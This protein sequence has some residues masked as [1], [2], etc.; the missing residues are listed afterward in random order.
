MI[1]IDERDLPITVAQKLITAT[2][3]IEAPLTK[4]I[5]Q[6]LGGDGTMDA[7]S[8]DEL[9]EIAEYLLIHCQHQ[10]KQQGGQ[11]EEQQEVTEECCELESE[12]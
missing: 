6:L 1:E 12:P 3:V 5:N 2:R 9:I 8:D 10:E 4:S 11:Q 7:F